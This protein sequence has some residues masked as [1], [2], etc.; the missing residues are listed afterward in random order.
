MRLHEKGGK[1]HE[2][3]CHQMLEEYLDEYLAA[4]EKRVWTWRAEK[5]L[6]Y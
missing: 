6:L 5:N 2:V 3:P 4:A 1:E